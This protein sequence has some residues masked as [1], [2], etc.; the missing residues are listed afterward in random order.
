[1]TSARHLRLIC[2]DDVGEP[3]PE[4]WALTMKAAGLS[5]RT[6]TDRTQLLARVSRQTR[7]PPEA[8]TGAELTRF[9]A[10][11]VSPGTRQTYHSTL[12]SWHRWLVVQGHRQDDPTL[13]IPAPR[14]PRR[15]PRPVMDEHLTVLLNTRMKARTRALILLC[16]YQGLRIGEA[17]TVRG[18]HVDVIGGRLR[19]L[20]KGGTDEVI[21][22]HPAVAELA[23]SYPRSGWW[24]PAYGPNVDRPDGGGPILPRS[25]STIVSNVMRRAGV[26]GTAHSLRHWTATAMLRGGADARVVQTVLRHANL[27]T[28]ALYLQVDADQQRAAIGALP[29][30]P[31][32]RKAGA[33]RAAVDAAAVLGDG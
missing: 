21:P 22:L 5:R 28:T 13:L 23:A 16:A 4:Q 2:E 18:E 20:G 33:S 30:V 7:K 3:L 14:V 25:A 24:F 9:L 11:P 8:S 17:C 1:M 31:R 27:A 19:V 29:A 26:P 12:K 10:A 32:K 6:I 15:H